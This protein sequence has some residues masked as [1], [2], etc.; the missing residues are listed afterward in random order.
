VHGLLE[1]ALEPLVILLQLGIFPFE[2]ANSFGVVAPAQ[3]GG[4][5]RSTPCG[6]ARGLARGANC[7]MGAYASVA[8]AIMAARASSFSPI[9]VRNASETTRAELAIAA[10]PPGHTHAPRARAVYDYDSDP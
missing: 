3:G 5:S 7:G 8:S 1:L 2:R 6:L 4:L 9:W 10:D